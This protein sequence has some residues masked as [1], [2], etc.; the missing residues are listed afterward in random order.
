MVLLTD[1]RGLRLWPLLRFLGL[2]P[3]S[4]LIGHDAVFITQYGLGSDFATA[5]R[6]GGHDGYWI[7]FSLVILGLASLGLARSIWRAARLSRQA[8]ECTS[9]R[10]QSGKLAAVAGYLDEVRR[11]WP[12]LFVATAAGFTIQENLEHL[13]SGQVPHGLG[14]LIGAEHPF[15]IPVLAVVALAVAAVGGVLRWRVRI[16]EARIALAAARFR[17]ARPLATRPAARWPAI[18]ALR[19]LLSFL[20]RLD[21][22]RAPPL[23]G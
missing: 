23:A 6:V 22:G 20:V 9:D 18:A 2:V 21:A 14:S 8:R 4:V 1:R 10:G 12:R 7:A 3:L 19:M 11:I 13:A 17:W 16:L 15:S 5:M